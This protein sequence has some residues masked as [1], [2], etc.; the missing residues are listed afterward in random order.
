MV[1]GQE[2]YNMEDYRSGDQKEVLRVQIEK[3]KETTEF[4]QSITLESLAKEAL[5]KEPI[6]LH[7]QC[8]RKTA[9]IKNVYIF[10]GNPIDISPR[11]FIKNVIKLKNVKKFQTLECFWRTAIKNL[12]T[13][14]HWSSWSQIWRRKRKT[15]FKQ[16]RR[17]TE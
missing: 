1:E 11:E 14:A 9:Q 3:P 2:L 17:L 13:K 15:S 5:I 12:S 10:D 4:T 7:F 16:S 6:K 8:T